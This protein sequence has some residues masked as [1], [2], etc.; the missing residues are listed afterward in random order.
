MN[1]FDQ[2]VER[3]VAF[4]REQK[5]TA[6]TL[7]AHRKCYSELRTHLTEAGL[8]Y[9][10]E[11]ALDWIKQE[12][13]HWGRRKSANYKHFIVHLDDMDRL[14]G[15]PAYHLSHHFPPFTMRRGRSQR[16]WACFW[17]ASRLRTCE[18]T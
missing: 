2:S 16:N 13:E 15:I 8:G 17:T 5:Y 11:T 6:S 3:V 9:S 1:Q 14:G 10:F 4:L 7:C 12:S 18:R